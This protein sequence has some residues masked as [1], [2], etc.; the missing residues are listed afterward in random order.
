M[1]YSGS[2]AKLFRIMIIATASTG[3][4]CVFSNRAIT[5]QHILLYL[6]TKYNETKRQSNLGTM[7]ENETLDGQQY[8]IY[9]L[10]GTLRYV[11]FK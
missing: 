8:N 7:C 1:Q 2:I 3:L 11:M 10:V 5:K 4:L 9:I 6:K